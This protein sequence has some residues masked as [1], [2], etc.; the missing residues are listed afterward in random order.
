MYC[1]EYELWTKTTADTIVNKVGDVLAFAY[2]IGS[3]I[4]YKTGERE[5]GRIGKALDD[6]NILRTLLNSVR[7]IM[8]DPSC[9]GLKNDDFLEKLNSY[10]HLF[11]LANCKVADYKTGE[12]RDRK[13]EDYFT[14]TT[15]CSV[16]P[17]NGDLKHV[18]IKDFN[19]FVKDVMM[20]PI[21]EENKKVK[22]T[23]MRP[24]P[25]EPQYEERPDDEED[26]KFCFGYSATGLVDMSKIYSWIGP[27]STSKSTTKDIMYG[28][29]T[30][31]YCNPALPCGAFF[32]EERD[33]DAEKNKAT[34]ALNTTIGKR[35]SFIEEITRAMRIKVKA[36]KD[37]CGAKYQQLRGN[38]NDFAEVKTTSKVITLTNCAHPNEDTTI[39][40]NLAVIEF[41][42]V[43][44]RRSE[45]N[46]EIVAKFMERNFLDQ[47]YTVAFHYAKKI[48]E[49]HG[50]FK[51]KDNAHV[52][53]LINKYQSDSFNDF[54]NEFLEKS[55]NGSKI[56]RDKILKV[57]VWYCKFRKLPSLDEYHF[58]RRL[59]A[60]FK[61]DHNKYEVAWNIDFICNEV[62][63]SKRREMYDDIGDKNLKKAVDDAEKAAKD[64]AAA[65]GS[66]AG[67]EA[68]DDAGK[69]SE[70]ATRRKAEKVRQAK[71]RLVFFIQLCGV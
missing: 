66:T 30:K 12:V 44:D 64:A 52:A 19:D 69:A 62:Y 51:T 25:F 14:Y 22:S 46:K 41:A 48:Y 16:L 56:S 29:L 50:V 55:E 36:V 71:E 57:Y 7:G 49:H 40:E 60:L 8:V 11:P 37:W 32:G 17:I 53:K 9:E 10:D 26:L 67:G 35:V 42:H 34:L 33:A 38:F 24:N 5:P 1:E 63:P 31:Q 70:E 15:E 3:T 2:D 45:K 58:G 18:I 54:Q 28:M 43:K 21:N 59:G 61:K 47:A 65:K 39:L 68:L 4:N 20:K 6:P 13:A 27:R 23:C